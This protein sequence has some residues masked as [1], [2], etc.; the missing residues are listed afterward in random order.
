MVAR[1][2]ALFGLARMFELHRDSMGLQVQVVH[3][4]DEAYDLLKVRP[5]DFSLRLFPIDAAA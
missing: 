2:P 4:V 3:S 5:Q 1:Q